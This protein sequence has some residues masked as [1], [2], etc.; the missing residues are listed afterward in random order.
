MLNIVERSSLLPELNV[1]FEEI[2]AL[3]SH[4]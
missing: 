1:V 2:K 4:N 3:L